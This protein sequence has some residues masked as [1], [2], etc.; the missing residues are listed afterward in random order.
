MSEQLNLKLSVSQAVRRTEIQ[1][2]FTKFTLKKNL[3][4]SLKDSD[5]LFYLGINYTKNP[6]EKPWLKASARGVNK[7]N[8]FNNENKAG[9]AEKRRLYTNQSARKTMIQKLND[10]KSSSFPVAVHSV[11]QCF[12]EDSSA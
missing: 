9:F 5:S 4:R 7:L 10:N 6:T 8:G 11:E 12:T 2:L 1:C 3:A